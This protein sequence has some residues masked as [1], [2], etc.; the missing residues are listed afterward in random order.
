MRLESVVDGMTINGKTDSHCEPCILRKQTKFTSKKTAAQAKYPLELVSSDVCGPI[1]PVSSDGF[2]YVVSF[3]DNYSGYTFLYF[4]KEKSD[5][6]KC[7]QKCLADIS[8]LGKVHCLSDI[9][10]SEVKKLRSDGGGE[11]ME[12]DFKQVLNGIAERGWRAFFEMGRCLLI[13]SGLSCFL[14]PYVVMASSYIRNRCF[15]ERTSQTPYFLLTGRKPNISNMHVFGSVC[16]SYIEHHKTKLDPRSK[17]GIFIGFAKESPAFL[18]YYSD[19]RKV[20]KCRCVKFTDMIKKDV[21][22]KDDAG[23]NDDD[24]PGD[25]S[26]LSSVIDMGVPPAVPVL[27]PSPVDDVPV[28]PADDVSREEVERCYPSRDRNRPMYLAN[29]VLDTDDEVS[30]CIDFCKMMNADDVPKS[31]TEAIS[32]PDSREWKEAMDEEI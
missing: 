23:S 28:L 16:Y 12:K 22:R 18:V 25:G 14:W 17:R 10:D 32:S 24:F 27:Q 3:I 13:G 7:L 2:K 20:I 31:Y 4:M 21:R 6:E 8:P 1:N 30:K 19:T 26:P 9:T 15:Q 5:A 29:Y 11:F